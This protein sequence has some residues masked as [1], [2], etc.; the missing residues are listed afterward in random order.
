MNA[1]Q[2]SDLAKLGRLVARGIP[3]P[4]A[5]QLE[6]QIIAGAFTFAGLRDEILHSMARAAY[7]DWWICE[8]ERK[9]E[10]TGTPVPWGPG[11]S[12]DP[13]IPTRT[14]AS[15][16]KWALDAVA[17]W[18]RETGMPIDL[19]Y[20]LAANAEGHHDREPSTEQF[21]WYLGMQTLGHGVSW[22]DDHPSFEPMSGVRLYHEYYP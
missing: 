13:Y 15:A 5:I 16:K 1:R 14:P 7:S 11:E 18:E 2:R 12:I 3:M 21:G 17:Q 19:L 4:T 9:F 6:Q 20:W 10:E 8:Q 22:F